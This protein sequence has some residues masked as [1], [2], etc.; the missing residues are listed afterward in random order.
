MTIFSKNFWGRTARFAPPGY[1]YAENLQRGSVL[2]KSF[3]GKFGEIRAK[4]SSNPPKIACSYTYRCCAR[5]ILR[6]H[7]VNLIPIAIISSQAFS[8]KQLKKL[9]E[10]DAS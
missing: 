4:Y 7:F 3:T 2:L 8:S 9:I 5:S 10:I 1:A 6:L